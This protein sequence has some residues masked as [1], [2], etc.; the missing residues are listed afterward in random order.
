MNRH[1]IK[2][3]LRYLFEVLVIS[4]IRGMR[5]ACSI[6]N[7]HFGK[8]SLNKPYIYI[9]KVCT[10]LFFIWLIFTHILAPFFIWWSGLMNF[11]NYVIWG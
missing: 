6:M 3:F 9:W 5:K 11:F 7:G 8:V 4:T 10:W 1:N 2:I